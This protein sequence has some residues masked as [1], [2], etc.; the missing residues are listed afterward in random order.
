MVQACIRGPNL[1]AHFFRD[2]ENPKDRSTPIREVDFVAE[3]IDGAVLP[4]E[5]KFRKKIDSADKAGV[6]LFMER[7]PSPVGVMVTRELMHL[8]EQARILCIP[9]QSF[10]LAF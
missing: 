8:D 5:V 6:R 1:Q 2:H 4:V 3:K 9:L 7:Y 10:L